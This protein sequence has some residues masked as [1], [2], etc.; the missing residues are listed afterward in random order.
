MII[1]H[2]RQF[3]LIA[4]GNLPGYDPYLSADFSKSF[5]NDEDVAIF[6]PPEHPNT[7]N[8]YWFDSLEGATAPQ[9]SFV[10]EENRLVQNTEG[11]KL[12]QK[13]DQIFPYQTNL[14]LKMKKTTNSPLPLNDIGSS[15][16]SGFDGFFIKGSVI[17]GLQSGAK[18]Y[19]AGPFKGYTKETECVCDGVTATNTLDNS[20]CRGWLKGSIY[21]NNYNPD[22]SE[23]FKYVGEPR[24]NIDHKQAFNNGF[25]TGTA[26]NGLDFTW[27]NVPYRQKRPLP[28]NMLS[29]NKGNY[30]VLIG[31]K[32]AIVNA[33]SDIDLDNY[34]F[35]SES[36]GLTAVQ[37]V[38]VINNFQELWDACGFIPVNTN[39]TSLASYQA[40]SKHFAGL[41]MVKFNEELPIDIS[42][43]S[44][45]DPE[46]SDPIYY[47]LALGQDGRGHVGVFCPPLDGGNT[48]GQST[49]SFTKN[50]ECDSFPQPLVIGGDCCG[51]QKNITVR[52]LLLNGT[53][54][55]Y[56]VG[57]VLTGDMG[58]PV[59]TYWS[60][61]P[62][63][64]GFM[65]EK[66]YDQK[67]YA[68]LIGVGLG[69]SKKYPF[70]WGTSFG[71]VDVFNL[72]MALTGEDMINSP[73]KTTRNISE[74]KYPYPIGFMDG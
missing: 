63:F 5:I 9:F 26:F 51:C 42:P 22:Y 1:G 27:C 6:Y 54:D 32:H 25:M 35:Y 74:E 38:S 3:Y 46:G 31:K 34:R 30:A 62:V 70:H 10:S 23:I 41:K 19:Y 15:G 68:K 47:A 56:S 12:V 66:G 44:F 2:D 33:S 45:Y 13:P 59:I 20:D 40:M 55:D 14:H 52:S 16:G 65:N 37:V 71:L 53:T 24:E 7:N 39:A 48:S 72:F 43:I 4:A 61:R 18:R 29:D 36:A 8:P 64:L 11:N 49:L 57:S 73:I 50:N 69:S 58:G 17:K 28:Y 60:D 67:A 21:E